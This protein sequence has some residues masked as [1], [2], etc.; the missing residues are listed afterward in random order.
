MKSYS[1]QTK[2]YGPVKQPIVEPFRGQNDPRAGAEMVP[3]VRLERT[4]YRLQGGC[5]TS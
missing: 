5:S 2:G 1:S 3:S 4:T